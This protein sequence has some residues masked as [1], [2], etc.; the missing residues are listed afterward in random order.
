MSD[1]DSSTDSDE[2]RHSLRRGR[3]TRRGR[4]NDEDYTYNDD[5][6][7]DGYSRSDC[8]KVEKHLLIY[9]WAE[10]IVFSFRDQQKCYDY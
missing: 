6:S 1:L 7:T 4:G 9:G 8:F 3:K 2:E 5:I 10:M